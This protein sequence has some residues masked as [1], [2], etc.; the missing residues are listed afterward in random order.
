MIREALKMQFT[1]LKKKVRLTSLVIGWTLAFDKLAYAASDA[2][3]ISLNNTD[4]VVLLSFIA[5]L[6]VLLYLKVP[7][8]VSGLLDERSRSIQEDIDNATSILED[9][10]KML[11]DLEREHKINI[12]K[13]KQIVVDAE[14]EAKNI[15]SEA[16][17]E[18]RLSIERKVRLAEDQ[19]KATEA[20]V[21]QG[22]KN[23]AIEQ[24]IVL[25]EKDLLKKAS[26]SVGDQVLKRS[27]EDLENEI[28]RLKH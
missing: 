11:A 17:R 3:A 13:S 24:S 6:A 19:I 1:C 10:K 4:F 21:V 28:R 22:I 2:P 25:A 9:S 16:K 8:K 15:L 7:S 20:A 14:V 12:A 26:A 18:V 27:I 5:F 23:K